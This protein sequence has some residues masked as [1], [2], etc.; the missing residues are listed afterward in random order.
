MKRPAPVAC[1]CIDEA[2]ASVWWR[3][4]G[5]AFLAMNGMVFSVALNGSE[6]TR[7][8]RC[9]LELTILCVALPVFL[10]LAKEF[11][12]A[13]WRA[14]RRRQLSIELLFLMGIVASL[15]SSMM[16]FLRG[17]GNGYADVAAMLLVV[18]ALGRQIG[19]Y[20]KQRVLRQLAEWT[21]G[22]IAVRRVNGEMTTADQIAPGDRIR[23]LPGERVPVDCRVVHGQ[24]FFH[25]A[26]ITG[27]SFAVARRP[28]DVLAAG[29]YPLDASVD[30]EAVAAPGE[31]QLDQIRA[32]IEAGLARPGAEQ[33]LA[34]AALRWFVPLVALSAVAAFLWHWRTMPWDEALFPALAVAV[35]ACPCALGFATPLAVWTAMARLREW[36][37]LTRSGETVEKLAEIDTVIFDKTGTLTLPEQYG[38]EWSVEPAWRGREGE[39]LYLLRETELASRHPLA[40]V[41]EPLWAGRA[42]TPGGA[43]LHVKLVPGQ[44][45]EAEFAGGRR[46]FVGREMFVDGERAASFDLR[47]Q[48]AVDLPPA[49]RALEKLGIEVMLATGDAAERAAVMPIGRRMARQT[50]GGKHALVQ[51]LN[52][53][54]R[55][56]LFAGDGVN[57]AAAMAHSHVACAAPH[58]AD[59]VEGLSGLVF[60]HQ[61]WG[62][63][64][65]AIAMARRT[66]HVVR[67]NIRF[68]LAYNVVGIA[69]A[70]T[71]WLHPVASAL[72]MT[73]SSL[74]VI[75]YSMHLMDW[76]AT[77]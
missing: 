70:V 76:E 55:K 44:G 1:A 6:V 35:V 43:L 36:G 7:E 62:N 26:H 23:I 48:T 34:M 3:I 69:V 33:R 51:Q 12:E 77:D 18:Y 2:P 5:G 19:A 54:G 68:S 67:W 64:A 74:T 25:E 15:A 31:N 66:R 11:G 59:V 16:F 13:T 71:G 58:S 24:A 4:G 21:P 60:L 17:H 56:V 37:I 30:A 28:G 61:D 39:L 8:E 75:L 38:V 49:V 47:E 9:A 65:R 45:V 46:V 10:L 14:L 50:P 20:G 40:R 41:L 52:G 32:W 63:L 53:E 29:A 42:V 22:S 57:D 73:A 27:E 72:V